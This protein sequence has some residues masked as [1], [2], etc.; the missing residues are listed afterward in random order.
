MEKFTSNS[1]FSAFNCNDRRSV[2]IISNLYN[3]EEVREVTRRDKNIEQPQ[4]PSPL[5]VADDNH[6]MKYVDEFIK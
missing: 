5:A 1:G 4:L 3:S 6:N 2:H